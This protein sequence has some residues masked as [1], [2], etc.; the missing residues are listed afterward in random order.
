MMIEVRFRALDASD[1]LRAHAV[2][3]IHFQMSRFGEEVSSVLVR[4]SDVN[5]PRGGPDK[6]C[7]VTVR[8]PTLTPVSVDDLS[9]DPY[10]AVDV[11]VERAARAVGRDI[12]RAR[13]KLQPSPRRKE[14]SS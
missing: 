4:I 13:V 3:R 5:G 8:G 10:A 12:E 2:R 1:A 11:A 7:H 6:R 9:E 14:R